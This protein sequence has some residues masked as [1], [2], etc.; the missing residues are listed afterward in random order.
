M[1]D[2]IDRDRKGVVVFAFLM[3]SC[4]HLCCISALSDFLCVILC[5]RTTLRSLLLVGTNFSDFHHYLQRVQ[6]IKL[7]CPIRFSLDCP[8][9]TLQ[10][11]WYSM[12]LRDASCKS[13][14]WPPSWSTSK[15]IRKIH[16]QTLFHAFIMQSLPLM[17]DQCRREKQHLELSNMLPL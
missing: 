2:G 9:D 12:K 10:R 17:S 7:W 6:D 3:A 4:G 1:S 13:V 15:D 11:P 5:I 8:I 16:E 14:Y